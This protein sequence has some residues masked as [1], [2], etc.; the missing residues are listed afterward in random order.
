M[1]NINTIFNNIENPEADTKLGKAVS[2]MLR[3]NLKGQFKDELLSKHG[4]QKKQHKGT[5]RI[6]RW[7]GS[8]AA[9]LLLIGATMFLLR[10][11]NNYDSLMADY[12]SESPMEH[13][14]MLKGSDDNT[15]ET[16]IIAYKKK[17][18]TKAIEAF[19]SIG[20]PS[21]ND[22]FYKALSSFYGK[23]YKQAIAEFETLPAANYAEEV[24]WYL[25]LSY[26][27]TAN[28]SKAKALLQDI[29]SDDWKFKEAQKLLKSKKLKNIQ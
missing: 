28:F 24:N 15:R 2:V 20:R 22:L 27:K 3:K 16:A 17:E 6:S 19:S 10:P 23:N 18:W 13:P 11:S 29:G 9:S 26:L 1:E 7:A 14:G 8:I 4:V 12:I 25:A 5:F 21:A